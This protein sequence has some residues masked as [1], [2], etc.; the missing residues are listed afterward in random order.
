MS[1]TT[2]PL[3]LAREIARQAETRLMAIMQLATA[4]DAR[5]TTLCGIF[6][7]GSVGLGA[8][9][10]AYLGVEHHASRLIATGTVTAVLLL[11]ASIIAGCAGAPRD[12]WLAGGMPG[13][14]RSWA[15]NGTQWRSEAEMLDGTAQRLAEAIDRDRQLLELESRL[16]ISSLY[17]AG[18][19]VFVGIS[20]YLIFPCFA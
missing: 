12:F 18:F 5:A 19:S 6:G 4:A 11:T 2:I 8:A 14:L 1:N 9:V 13:A 16:V 17:V 15:W 7:A 10:L 20:V 3:E